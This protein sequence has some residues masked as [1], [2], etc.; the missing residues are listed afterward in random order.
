[1]LQQHEPLQKYLSDIYP[2]VFVD[3]LRDTSLLQLELLKSLV[4]LGSSVVFGVADEDQVLYE[5]RDARLETIN[6]FENYFRAAPRFLVLNY[7]SPEPIVTVANTLIRNN[8]D[9]YEEELKSAVTDRPGAVY[10]HSD[11]DSE[12]DFLAKSLVMAIEFS[13]R[14]W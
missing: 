3:E 14:A 11:S 9:R 2:Y 6:E 4:D 1:M 5:W 10:I 7:R 13:L 8:P 12:A